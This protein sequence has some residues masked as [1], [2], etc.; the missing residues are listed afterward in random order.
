MMV[1]LRGL[2]VDDPDGA[3]TAELQTLE[4]SLQ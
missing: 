2:T 1:N 4:F 3:E